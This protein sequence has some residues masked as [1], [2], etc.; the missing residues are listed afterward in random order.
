MLNHPAGRLLLVAAALSAALSALAAVPTFWRIESQADFLGG[1][2]DGVSISSDGTVSLAPAAQVLGEA[3]D[4]QLWSLASAAAGV[5]YAGSGNDGRI[6]KVDASGT[7]NVFVDTNELQVH[8][9]VVDRRG[10]LYAGTSPRG[11]VY[12]IDPSGAQEVFF[13][14]EDRY[15]WALALD[16]LNNLLVATGDKAQIHRVS[17][18]GESEVLFTSEET[19]VVSLALDGSDNIY[20]GT[21]SNGLV[22]KVDASGDASVLFDTPFEEARALVTDTRGHVFVATVNGG[23][24]PVSAPSMPSSTPSTPTS[25]TSGVTAS[26]TVTTSATPA[27]TSTSGTSGV[28]SSGSAKGALYRI[29]ADGTAEELWKFLDDTP[30]S[31][32]LATDDRLMVGTG[33]EGRVFLVNQNKTS[34]LLL[35]VEAD[36]VTEIQAGKGGAVL[37]A[38]ANPAKV[39]RLNRGRRTEG[40]YQ[41]PTKD[42]ET[43]S[44]WGRIRWEARVPS[45]TSVA[46]QTRSGNSAEPDN[47]WSDWSARY[48]E[49]TGTQIASPRARFFQWR[50]TLNSTGE[51][52]PEIL[53]VTAIY[54][55]QNLPPEVAG[56]TIHPPGRV[57]QKPIVTTG[58]IEVLGMVET[59]AD[60]AQGGNDVA[61]GNGA[62][63]PPLNLTAMSRPVYRK[64]IQTVTWNVTDP[65][66]DD[67][68]FDVHYRAEGENLWRVLREGLTSPVIAWDT[69]AMPDGRY[70][71]K[72]IASDLPGN[73]A[74]LARTRER[75][76]RSFEVDNTPPRVEA[77]A[78][79]T[80][81]S[82]GGHQVRF[83]ARDEISPIRRVEYTI[84]SGAWKVVFPID[85]I[86][87]STEES[88]AFELDGYGDGGVYTLVVKLTD[89]LGNVGTARADLR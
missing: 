27:I 24:R 16:S 65:N 44:F 56:I 54:L 37:L 15:I 31:L 87:D 88:F 66:K 80:S 81:S 42:T 46:I 43:V 60:G 67:L 58:Q 33:K 74:D 13:D 73:P 7:M 6:Y 14:P 38:T 48:T 34:S 11:V 41:S 57:F 52:S 40:I 19:H 9:L 39:Y 4:P 3:T 1:D 51:T 71:L 20:A 70:T 5:V 28:R 17:S 68:S 32:L 63:T 75:M 82:S 22:L 30:L 83:V 2:T 61:S 86:A 69:V 76:S 18:S 25:V 26:V 36:Q 50:A 64:G 47:T 62:S 29:D 79:S 45:G 35:S 84:N 12:R 72:V 89:G 21:A 85:G 53:D 55:Q 8:A 77:L 59:L 49:G 78:V 10:N 23:S